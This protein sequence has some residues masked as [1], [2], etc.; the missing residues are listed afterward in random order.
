[1]RSVYRHVEHSITL[2]S[3]VLANVHI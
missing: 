1:M 2:S 3:Y